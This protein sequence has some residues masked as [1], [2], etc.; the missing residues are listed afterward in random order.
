MK[1]IMQTKKEEILVVGISLIVAIFVTLDVLL[2]NSVTKPYEESEGGISTSLA[3]E[4][5]LNLPQDDEKYIQGDEIMTNNHLVYATLENRFEDVSRMNT[6]SLLGGNNN[7]FYSLTTNTTHKH[8]WS[9]WKYNEEIHWKVCSGCGNYKSVEYHDLKVVKKV[10]ATCNASGYI[11]YKCKCGFTCKK[12]IAVTNKHVYNSGVIIKSPTCSERGIKK[13]TCLNCGK[14]KKTYVAKTNKHVYDNPVVY[15]A[16]TCTQEGINVYTCKNCGDK[17]YEYTP[18]TDHYYDSGKVTLKATCDKSGVKTYTCRYCGIT[19]TESV[20]ATNFHECI[21]WSNDDTKH[22]KQCI[23]CNKIYYS[24]SHKFDSGL[25]TTQPTEDATGIKTYTCTTCGFKKI[26]VLP[27]KQQVR[28]KLELVF[29][30]EEYSI[31]STVTSTIRF[32][33]VKSLKNL[34]IFASI[35]EMEYSIVYSG[36]D[37]VTINIY[38]PSDLSGILE[39]EARA[40]NC[41]SAFKIIKV[42]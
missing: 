35:Y 13:Y 32:T 16:A 5:S 29:G 24:D 17:H 27:K 41:D 39:M 37:F 3:I 4:S 18:K 33:K 7:E 26:E 2:I 12:K 10:E 19:K 36:K 1:K 30:Q 28:G 23:N 25:I 8:S 6:S 15:R 31:G 20:P 40:D 38:M 34:Q 42:Q 14:I 11:K 22:W 9:S 21:Y